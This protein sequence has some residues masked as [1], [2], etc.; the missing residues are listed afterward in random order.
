MFKAGDMVTI[1][2]DARC[3]NNETKK[4]LGKTVEVKSTASG[5]FLVWDENKINESYWF[6]SELTLVPKFKYYIKSKENN[7]S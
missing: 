3:I 6:G 7:E 2:Y 4:L 1:S 5:G